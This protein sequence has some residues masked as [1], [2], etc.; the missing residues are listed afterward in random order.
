MSEPVGPLDEYEAEKFLNSPKTRRML[1]RLQPA[2]RQAVGG[3]VEEDPIAA[4]VL[5][6]KHTIPIGDRGVTAGY[7]VVRQNP[8]VAPVPSDLAALLAKRPLSGGGHV[9]GCRDDFER[10]CQGRSR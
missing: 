8:V 7:F 9:S 4:S 6:V 1:K 2:V 5:D 3:R 10:Q